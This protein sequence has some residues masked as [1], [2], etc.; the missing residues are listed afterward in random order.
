MQTIEF[1]GDY[2]M[3]LRDFYAEKKKASTAFSYRNFCKKA[4]LTSPSIFK[5]VAEG[6]RNLTS[7]TISAFITGLGLSEPESRFFENLVLFNQAKTEPLKQKYLAILRGLKYKKP[8]RMIP[9]QLYSFYERWYNPVVRELAVAMDWKN[10]YSLLARA[11]VPS[12]KTSEARESVELQLQLGFLGRNDGGKFV[13]SDPDISTGAEVSSL[14]I[15]QINRDFA[16]LG[17]EAID[18]FPPSQRD[19]SSL[20]VGVPKSKLPQLKQE[21]A[22]FRKRLVALVDSTEPADSFYTLMLEFFPVG[23]TLLEKEYGDDTN[24]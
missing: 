13:Q 7:A 12:I 22:E 3:F 17:L 2:R 6:K 8:Q 5:E 19:I 20:V 23:R 24:K 18:R 14:A 15:R 10:N 4:R 9:V 11:V 16:R 1:Y 21:I